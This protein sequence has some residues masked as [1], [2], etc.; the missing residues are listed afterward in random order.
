MENA[1]RTHFIPHEN[2]NFQNLSE[3]LE[4]NSM[5]LKAGLLKITI[6]ISYKLFLV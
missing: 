3:F 6:T 5:I 4:L 1:K 2:S